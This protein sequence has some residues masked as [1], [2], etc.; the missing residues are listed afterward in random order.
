M[1]GLWRL[2]VLGVL[3]HSAYLWSI[4]DIYFTSP[5]THGMAPVSPGPALA[6]RLVLLVADGL[7]ADRLFE[8]GMARAPHLAARLR[9]GC[10]GLSHT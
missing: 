6:S 10:W 5:L 9:D 3:F 2:L 8:A 4:F 7:R 1:D